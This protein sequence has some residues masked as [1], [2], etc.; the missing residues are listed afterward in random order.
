MY[1]GTMNNTN[2]TLRDRLSGS[3]LP[4]VL[5]SFGAAIVTLLFVFGTE[6]TFGA[7]PGDISI[8]AGITRVYL[9]LATTVLISVVVTGLFHALG[10]FFSRR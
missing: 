6:I 2:R 7:L 10:S 1:T 3:I 8:I 4:L 5:W 9:P